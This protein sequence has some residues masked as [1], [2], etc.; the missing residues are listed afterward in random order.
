MSRAQCCPVCGG[1]G[2]V[3]PGF[4]TPETGSMTTGAAWETC[5]SCSGSGL[6]WDG[7]ISVPSPRIQK[8]ETSWK[9]SESES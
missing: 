2:K 5:R 3:Q 9:P 6:V 7:I 8:K 1:R 4:Y